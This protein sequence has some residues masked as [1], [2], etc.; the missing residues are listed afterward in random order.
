MDQHALSTR[1]DWHAAAAGSSCL[2]LPLASLRVAPDFQPSLA[3]SGS[4]IAH[5][6]VLSRL[7]EERGHFYLAMIASGF[8]TEQELEEQLAHLDWASHQAFTSTL[9]SRLETAVR[10]ELESLGFPSNPAAARYG[11]RGW[12]SARGTTLDCQFYQGRVLDLTVLNRLRPA[13]A[14]FVAFAIRQAAAFLGVGTPSD[15][16]EYAVDGYSGGNLRAALDLYLREGRTQ[17][18][19]EASWALFLETAEV[20]EDGDEASPYVY[21]VGTQQD[22][23]HL[24]GLMADSQTERKR[25]CP[26]KEGSRPEPP[27]AVSDLERR[28]IDFAV[29]V[30][31]LESRC[32]QRGYQ[33]RHRSGEF[34]LSEEAH[35]IVASEADRDLIDLYY[36]A[37]N[38]GSGEVP[39][40]ELDLVERGAE[41]ADFLMAC[42]LV[43][44]VMGAF[45]TL[46]L[47]TSKEPH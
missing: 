31:S 27:S 39:G 45:E 15:L 41:I 4:V 17:A 33:L 25:L 8:S 18:A 19:Q 9:M 28:W 5:V 24:I 16:Y 32:R 46:A 30:S 21:G 7:L 43:P 12:L 3:A 26:I 40:L 44:C 14:H 10:A 23:N 42:T 2:H 35:L 36:E 6:G 22:F 47:E 29:G 13:V 11:R 38:D 20:Q 1:A 34:R 37:I